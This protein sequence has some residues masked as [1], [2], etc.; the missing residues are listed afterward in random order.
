M[1]VKW[2]SNE[3]SS[4]PRLFGD[5][6]SLFSVVQD[7]NLSTNALNNDLLE[8]NNWAYQWKTSFNPDLSK[9]AQE[10]NFSCEIRKLSHPILIFNNNQVIHTRCQKHSG[11]FSDE[12]LNF[13]EHLGMLITVNTCIELLRKLQKCLP[14]W[15]VVT[16]YKSF[17]RPNLD[18]AD[19]I[20]DQ[21]HNKSFHE[22]LRSLQYNASLAIGRAIRGT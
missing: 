8:I 18:Y 17:I 2:L 11:L 13:G 20:F 1:I 16:I 10:V 3:L 9:Q 21:V 12:K 15:S 19:V 4:S 7:T 14:R 22:S 6:T 5:D